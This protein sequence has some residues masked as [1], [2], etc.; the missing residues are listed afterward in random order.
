MNEAAF[1][2]QLVAW[3]QH[4]RVLYLRRNH[5]RSPAHG[6]CRTANGHVVALG[7]AGRENNFARI[8]CTEQRRHLLAGFIDIAFGA[9]AKG[10]QTGWVSPMGFKKRKHGLHYFGRYGRGGIVIKV[11]HFLHAGH[12]RD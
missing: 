2:L 7:T 10:M 5:M 4:R 1:L 6:R 11:D 9:A 8:G 12:F 3:P